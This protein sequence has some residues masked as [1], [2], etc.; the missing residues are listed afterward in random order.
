MK[1]IAKLVENTLAILGKG[2][3]VPT[4]T[5][6]E[7]GYK[8]YD[9]IPLTVSKTKNYKDDKTVLVNCKDYSFTCDR[10]EEV[11]RDM[12]FFEYEKTNEELN[13]DRKYNGEIYEPKN[14]LVSFT[15]EDGMAM[16]QVKAAFELGEINTNIKF[17]NG[18]IL[19]IDA[20][21]FMEFASWFVKKRNSF[22]V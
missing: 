9:I 21:E 13:H 15:K 17:S 22:F 12:E 4:K 1:Y 14:T 18:A 7:M 8:I 2:N 20:S 11:V 10:T 16:L 6:E 5:H 3:E 19:N